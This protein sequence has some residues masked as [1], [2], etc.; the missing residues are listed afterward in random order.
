MADM[1]TS[2]VVSQCN[3]ISDMYKGL[4]D[5]WTFRH[6]R[7]KLNSAITPEIA[8]VRPPKKKPNANTPAMKDSA[9]GSKVSMHRPNRKKHST[10]RPADHLNTLAAFGRLTGAGAG[11]VGAGVL[12]DDGTGAGVYC[13]V[14]AAV[15]SSSG[16]GPEGAGCWGS[17]TGVASAGWRGRVVKSS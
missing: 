10:P 5:L 6:F 17:A 12:Q 15:R 3:Y 9:S 4:V 11:S 8:A 2:H 14:F 1:I 7:N 13:G 16:V